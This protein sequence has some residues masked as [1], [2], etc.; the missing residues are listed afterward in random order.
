[1]ENNIEDEIEKEKTLIFLIPEI[2]ALLGG[3]ISAV[4]IALPTSYLLIEVANF[5][6]IQSWARQPQFRCVTRNSYGS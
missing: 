2:I 5:T 3:I 1:M 4:L 6:P